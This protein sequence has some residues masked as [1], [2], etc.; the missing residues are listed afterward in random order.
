MRHELAVTASLCIKSHNRMQKVMLIGY[1]GHDPEVKYTQQG[2]AIAQF[3]V[4][5]TE[6]WGNRD[7]ELQEHTEWFAV[8]TFGRRA[9]IVGEFLHTGSRVYLEGRKRTESW[10]DNQ[11]GGKRYRDFVY[12][13]RI[14]F[15]SSKGNGYGN[16]YQEPTGNDPDETTADQEPPF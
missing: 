8:K 5:T 16:G 10:D 14:E 4:A 2:R 3:S 15:L 13:D 9:E 6:R 7:G 11:S 12:A 1:L